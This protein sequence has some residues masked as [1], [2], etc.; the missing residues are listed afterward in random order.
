MADPR[1]DARGIVRIMRLHLWC[2]LMASEL[3]SP[4]V[5]LLNAAINYHVDAFLATFT[6]EGVVDDWSRVRWCG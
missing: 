2:R 3:P 4:V 1:L 5:R 6:E